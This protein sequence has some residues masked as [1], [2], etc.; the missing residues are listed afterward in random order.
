MRRTPR[1]LAAVAVAAVVAAAGAGCGRTE[2]GRGMNTTASAGKSAAANQSEGAIPRSGD[3]CGGTGGNGQIVRI[4]RDAFTIQRNDDGTSQIIHLTSRAT[5][6]TSVGSVSVSDLEIGDKVTLVGNPNPDGSFTA[7]AV[8][9][10]ARTDQEPESGRRAANSKRAASW[11]TRIN[12]LAV[13]LIG[14]VLVVIIAW[15]RFKRKASIVFLLFLTVFY[16][17]LVKV[18]DYTLFQFQSLI[19][20]KHFVPELIVRGQ[21]VGQICN[22]VP[23][24]TLTVGD[25]KTSLLNILLM[26]PFGF[27]LP[28]ITNLR[29]KMIVAVGVLFSIAIELS[30]L[31]TGLV[32][33]VTFRIAD[34]NDIIF[35]TIGVSTGYMLFVGFMRICRH[36]FRNWE[37]SANP[38]LRY[39]DE[40]PQA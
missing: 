31:I 15:F 16:V 25:L 1:P 2:N 10:C 19:V 18:L 3:L 37:I 26:V 29:F 32:G 21:E 28:F 6:K 20:L 40:R 34:V 8:V 11:S 39:I 22:L 4:G 14:L 36:A 12:M 17:Y 13:A 35:N 27:G 5:I 30:Q 24:F 38:I 33:G 7:N 23:L 9:V